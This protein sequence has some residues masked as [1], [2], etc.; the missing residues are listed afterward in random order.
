MA[1]Y[2]G[3]MAVSDTERGRVSNSTASVIYETILQSERE[4]HRS[5]KTWGLNYIPC[6]NCQSGLHASNCT[7]IAAAQTCFQK[8]AEAKT[9]CAMSL[10][11]NEQLC[12]HTCKQKMD[13]NISGASVL[14]Q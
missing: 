10:N 6:P 9:K 13:S 11:R 2:E 7:T 12:M 14:S 3:L 8:G 5:P 4:K 1:E